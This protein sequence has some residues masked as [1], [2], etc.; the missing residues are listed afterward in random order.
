ME[1]VD[2]AEGLSAGWGLS[3]SVGGVARTG[4]GGKSMR[5]L[6]VQL[7]ERES[8][9]GGPEKMLG[10]KDD[11]RGKEK[12]G[13]NDKDEGKGKAEGMPEEVIEGKGKA[14]ERMKGEEK[15][16]EKKKED[17]GN[18]KPD[19]R[20]VVDIDPPRHRGPDEKKQV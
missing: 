5:R 13:D 19:L 15:P 18:R 1:N 11:D 4:R 3:A 12:D 17:E 16:N 7:R 10:K 6:F 2:A 9:K 8:E 20:T 14:H